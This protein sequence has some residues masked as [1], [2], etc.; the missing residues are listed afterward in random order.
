[1]AKGRKL[2]DAQVVELRERHQFLRQTDEDEGQ[3]RNDS[4][5]DRLVA[6][7]F[8]VSISHVRD[9]VM[10]GSRKEAGGPIDVAR[11]ERF[12]LFIRER[13]ELGDT[14]AR[15]RLNLRSRNIDPNPK[16]IRYV[17]RVTVLDDLGRDTN[18][19]TV[20]EPGQSVR[21]EMVTEGGR[22]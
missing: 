3:P 16:E 11:R 19:S 20:L 8:G 22:R 13:G 10:G 7:E 9:L 6:N 2:T 1:M 21:V 17:Q 14:E 5:N 12:L 15:R 18:L 4:A